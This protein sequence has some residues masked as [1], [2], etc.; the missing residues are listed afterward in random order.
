MSNDEYGDALRYAM[1]ETTSPGTYTPFSNRRTVREDYVLSPGDYNPLI[2]QTAMEAL[3]R[4]TAMEALN[5]QR[6]SWV[7]AATASANNTGPVSLDSINTILNTVIGNSLIGFPVEI[8]RPADVNRPAIS[9]L[10]PKPLEDHQ[11]DQ[12]LRLLSE[13][14]TVSNQLQLSG[15]SLEILTEVQI[16]L[17][18]GEVLKVESTP[19]S[20][21]LEDLI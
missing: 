9:K 3:N 6:D 10:G 4:Q 15:T 20:I 18:T 5:R 1:S 11:L 2:T 17:S 13:S 21:E 16:T 14:L 19:D 8:N 12:V 7:H